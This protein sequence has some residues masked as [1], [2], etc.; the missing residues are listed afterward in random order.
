[1]LHRVAR[2]FT[3][4]RLRRGLLR[5]QEVATIMTTSVTAAPT[6]SPASNENDGSVALSV[7]VGDAG[8]LTARCA[9]MLETAYWVAFLAS[10]RRSSHPPPPDIASNAL[11]RTEMVVQPT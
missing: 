4:R 3:V 6:P 2:P 1:M 10:R 7:Q 8:R 9:L 5:H 11:E